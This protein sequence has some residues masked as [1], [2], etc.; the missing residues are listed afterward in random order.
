MAK[1]YSKHKSAFPEYRNSPSDSI[2]VN[3]TTDWDNPFRIGKDGT[4]E[5]VIVRFEGIAHQRIKRDPTWLDPLRGKDLICWCAR[6][7][8]CR[9]LLEIG[10]RYNLK[11]RDWEQPNQQVGPPCCLT[12]RQSVRGR[13]NSTHLD[14]QQDYQQAD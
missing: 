13:H 6:A 8:S 11:L 1:V 9:C 10:K 4:R 2:P 12:R 14:G 3:P 7:V 5:E